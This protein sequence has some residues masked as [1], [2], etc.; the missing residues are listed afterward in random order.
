MTDRSAQ[1]RH[2]HCGEIRRRRFTRRGYILVVVLG[3][4]V[5]SLST[6]IAY[7]EAHSSVMPEALNRVGGARA[8]YLA[9]SGIELASHYLGYPP[10]AVPLGD[11]WRGGNGLRIDGSADF[12]NV[13]VAEE[14]GMPGIYVVDSVGVA[15]DIDDAVRGKLNVRA[16]IM[17]PPKPIVRIPYAVQAGGN[18]TTEAP[19]T[20]NG[21]LH[22]EGD[23]EVIGLFS[24]NVTAT[25]TIKWSSPSVPDSLTENAPSVPTPLNDVTVYPTYIFNGMEY[26]AHSFILST[27]DETQAGILNSALDSE[28]DTNPGRVVV[29]PTGDLFMA[30]NAELRG[31]LVVDGRL[32]F[33][34]GAL[35]GPSRITPQSGFPA[36]VTRQQ[37]EVMDHNLSVDI[38]GSVVCQ[39]IDFHG[40]D[41]LSFIIRGAL[42]TTITDGLKNASGVGTSVTFD[43]DTDRSWYYDVSVQTRPPVTVLEWTD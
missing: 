26:T 40:K 41:N 2:R 29:T 16:R 24:G 15:H 18:L 31:T 23:L 10:D 36:V 4:A 8:R 27:L 17:I 28:L 39:K 38:V 32:K 14:A 37:I 25:G 1:L 12:I 33:V 3:I 35:P 42:V 34:P 6:G 43:W 13:A 9:E 19:V 7:M 5:V 30:S 21:D 20:I 11:Y 22:V